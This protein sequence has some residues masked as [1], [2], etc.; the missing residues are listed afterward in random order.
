MSRQADSLVVDGQPFRFTGINVYNANSSGQCGPNLTSGA[1]LDDA[2]SAMGPGVTVIRA[3]FFQSLATTGGQ[4]DWSAFDHTLAVAATHGV[5]VVATLANQWADCE[6][7]SGY[8]DETWYQSGYTQPDPGGTVSYLDWVGEVATRYANDPTVLAWQLMNEAEV[9]P[10]NI[11]GCSTNAEALLEAFAGDVGGAIKTADPNHLVSLGTIGSGQCGTSGDEYRQVHAIP[12]IDLCEFHDYDPTASIPGDEWNGL[13]VRIDQCATLGKPLFIGE[14]GIKVE[15]VGGLGE[16]ATILAQKIEAE[17]AA[18]IDGVLPW[19]WFGPGGAATTLYDIGPGDPV[20]DVLRH[21]LDP[22]DAST[23]RRVSVTNSGGESPRGG[24]IGSSPKTVS[25]DGRFV[26]FTSRSQL[27]PA[28]TRSDDADVYVRD[29]QARTTELISIDSS[30]GQGFGDSFDASISSDGRFVDFTSTAALDPQASGNGYRHI[31]VRDLV[32][33]TTSLVSV[34]DNEGLSDSEE[35]LSSISATGRYVTFISRAKNLGAVLDTDSDIDVF[36]RDTIAGTTEQISVTVDGVDDDTDVDVER[37]PVS[38]NGRY[39]AFSS[40]SADLVTTPVDNN[41]LPDVFVRDREAAGAPTTFRLSVGVGGADTDDV[42]VRPVMSDDGM[43]IAFM[44]GAT[45]LTP[46]PDTLHWYDIFVA[47]LSGSTPVISRA[48]P[49]VGGAEGNDYASNESISAD[50]RFI[51][52]QSAATNLAPT[53]PNGSISDI[54]VF[55]RIDGSLQRRGG[56][57]DGFAPSVNGDASV[58]AFSSGNGTLVENDGNGEQDVFVSLIGEPPVTVP[59]APTGL[60]AT[61]GDGQ[62]TVSWTAPTNDGGAPIDGY[63][64]TPIVN[65]VPGTPIPVASTQAVV[66]GLTNGTAYTFS[67][68][69]HNSVGDSTAA[70]VG[71]VTPYGAPG[72]VGGITVTYGD[73]TVTLSWPAAASNGE[74]IDGYVVTGTTA[75]APVVTRSVEGTTLQTTFSTLPHCLPYSFTV[76]AMNAAGPGPVSDALP[77]V[78]AAQARTVAVEDTRYVPPSITGVELCMRV[79]FAFAASVSNTKPHSV[80]DFRQ[81]GENNT[82][83]FLFNSGAVAP[84]GSPFTYLFQGAAFFTYRSTATGASGTFTG[85]VGFPVITS[86]TTATTTTPI[87]VR[88]GQRPAP[89]LVFDVQYSFRKAGKTTWGTWTAWL[90]G[91][92]GTHGSFTPSVVA[93]KNGPGTYKFRATL[94]NPTTKRTSDPSSEQTAW[95]VTVT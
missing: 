90:S 44:S 4:R 65:G 19:A 93:P 17:L 2:L 24:N 34:R 30:G 38:G 6:P 55:D 16:R 1:A 11:G 33:D 57:D 74:P 41:G 85:G 63:V 86:P 21:A 87:D 48:S 82:S 37:A 79:T 71:P 89:W 22:V 20:L 62:V 70:E 64:V 72:K 27:A 95:Y 92:T 15:D 32:D 68:V 28:D 10:S 84:G 39:V 88:W 69:A 3:W 36:L 56:T 67:V 40:G 54:W 58:I 14:L 59:D 80:T 26:V 46:T 23:T 51:A 66:T 47:D 94:R 5:R 53:D 78:V 8:K 60:S 91:Q 52:F 43:T 50:G 12:E 76:Q 35:L 31:Y 45:N 42:S 9:K 13:Q 49:G 25:E 29:R 77:G 18:E 73:G 81:L 7:A 83:R 61:S 75:E